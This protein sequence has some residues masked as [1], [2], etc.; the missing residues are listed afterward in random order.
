MPG[1]IV[2]RMSD[3]TS[4]GIVGQMSDRTPDRIAGQM[5]D[6]T[7]DRIVGRMSDRIVGRTSDR[8]VGQMSG[9]IVGQMS[10]RIV[11]QMSDRRV[12]GPT[13]ALSGPIGGSVIDSACGRE[14]RRGGSRRHGAFFRQCLRVQSPE[15]VAVRRGER[16]G[17][18]NIV[19]DLE[20]LA[21]AHEVGD[22][23]PT[24][25]ERVHD[26]REGARVGEPKRMA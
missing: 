20:L 9:R 5:S 12:G 17:P 26:V 10:D 7:S 1:Q 24:V 3:R 25:L 15:C 6:R 2:G 18:L 14:G 16:R 19:P 8:I 11:G 4:D 23:V 22:E 13:C 21:K